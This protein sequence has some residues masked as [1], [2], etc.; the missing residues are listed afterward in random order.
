MNKTKK[1]RNRRK[2]R[3]LR[4]LSK[5]ESMP[6]SIGGHRMKKIVGE[7]KL[8][9]EGLPIRS[10]FWNTKLDRAPL[11]SRHFRMK[12]GFEVLVTN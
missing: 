8:D 7:S 12:T 1:R 6:K 3:D 5:L 2:N 9:S 11:F 10:A 4:W